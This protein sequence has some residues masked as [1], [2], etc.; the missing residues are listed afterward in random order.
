[1]GAFLTE[2][3]PTRIRGSGQG[4]CYNIGK[5]IA[6]LFPLMI[7]MLG[8]NV[9]LGLGIGVF[10]AVSYGI[11]IVAALSLPETRGKQLQ[12]R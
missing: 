1:M 3:F 12:A 10:S 9:P 6:A 2:L 11:V 7:G 5:V 4:F 8:Q